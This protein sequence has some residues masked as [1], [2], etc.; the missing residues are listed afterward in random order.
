MDIINSKAYNGLLLDL[1]SK[2][3]NTQLRASLAAN[4]ELV[5]LYWQIGS[6][7]LK[8]EKLKGWGS[9]VIDKLAQDLKK[10]FPEIKGFSVRNLKY[11]RA[12]AEHYKDFN[13]VQQAPAQITWYHNTTILDKINDPN[14]RT[15]YIESTIKHGWS[16]NVL[17]HQIESG[18]YNR[19]AQV[20]K[21]HNYHET[22]AQ[23]QSELSHELLKDPYKFDFLGLGQEAKE[24]EIENALV[25]HLTKFLLELGT[26]FAF[27]GKQYHLEV[28]DQDFY[29]DLLFY[30]TKLH[31]YVVLELKT[32][33]FKPEYAGKLNFYLSVVDDKLKGELDNPSIGIILCKNKSKVV[34]EYSLKDLNKP[35]GV[36]EYHLTES[37][38]ENFK[39]SLPSIEELENELSNLD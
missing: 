36:S 24:K 30:H 3:R 27:I 10:E 14:A 38:P 7:I 9:K 13:F 31:A 39:A 33:N 37:I 5:T 20:T 26:G 19:Q 1:K 2:I 12:F 25:E 15:F 4:K 28:G 32:E 21:T 17:V 34:A 11:M 16:R 8:Q 18:L 23:A 29:I 35:I 22:L 6:S